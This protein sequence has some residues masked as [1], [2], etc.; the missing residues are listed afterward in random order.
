MTYRLTRNNRALFTH[1]PT[2]QISEREVAEVALPTASGE[3]NQGIIDSA[4]EQE[5]IEDSVSEGVMTTVDQLAEGI[6][7]LSIVPRSRWQTLL[8]LDLITV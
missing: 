8:H 6:T 4:F 7:T 5:E 3:G 2:R 1:I